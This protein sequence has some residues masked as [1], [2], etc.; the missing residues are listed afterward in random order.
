[1]AIL[2][3]SFFALVLI[4][5]LLYYIT[6]HKY[7]WVHLLIG[8]IVFYILSSKWLVIFPLLTTAVIYFVG[9]ALDR[10]NEKVAELK[11]SDFS[12]DEKKVLKEKYKKEKKKVVGI[13]VIASILLLIGTKYAGF[14]LENLNSVFRL[15]DSD[16]SLSVGK[17]LVP[18]GISYYTLEA[19]SYVVD[20]YRGKMKADR[21]FLHVL[22]YLLYFPK[23]VEGPISRFHEL[24]EAFFEN[25][26]L[27]FANITVGVDLIMYGLF[28]KMVIAD[29]A[30][31]FVNQVFSSITGGFITLLAMVLY[32][33]QIYA[34]FSGCIDIVRGVSY[35]FGIKL[36]LNFRQ[37]FFS[38]SIQEFWQ[39]WHMSLGAWIKEYVFF[40]ISLSRMNAKVT[41]FCRE[42]LSPRLFKFVTIAFPLFFVWIVNGIWH[43][44]S[45]KYVIYGMYYYIVMMIALLVKPWTDKILEKFKMNEHI[46]SCWRIF[47]TCVLVIIGMTLFRASTLNEFGTTMISLFKRGDDIMKYGLATIDF[48]ILI[49]G[50]LFVLGVSVAEEK[51]KIS[52]EEGFTWKPWVRAVVYTFILC[53]L[54]IF[55]VYGEGY[56]P[57]QFI[58]G[59]F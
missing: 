19:I 53:S 50:N 16:A 28:K 49:V 11:T 58:Y 3:F 24:K 31:I 25:N 44:A 47:R 39:R 20:I 48:V 29:R 18:L 22:L 2:S 9:L 40:P 30:G 6:P 43:G 7:R 32:T 51:K 12:D 15:F 17:L 45:Y 13:G 36:P 8:S 54:I 57:S 56:D 1:M 37:P 14:I 33:V 52:L 55:G 46:L 23:V 59:A 35:L 10:D 26:K 21:N 27:D 41:K 42:K 4:L 38:K 5:L 34:E